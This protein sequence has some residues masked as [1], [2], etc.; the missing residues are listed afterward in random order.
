M[1]VKAERTAKMGCRVMLS[2]FIFALLLAAVVSTGKYGERASGGRAGERASG[3]A[4]GRAGDQD[5]IFF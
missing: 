3:R 1:V 5:L 4:G 2:I